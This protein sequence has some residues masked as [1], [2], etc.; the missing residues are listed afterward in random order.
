MPP[1]VEALEAR[2]LRHWTLREVHAKPPRSP[3]LALTSPLHT[4]ALRP[5]PQIAPT[6]HLP[7]RL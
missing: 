4:T 1:A 7:S 5:L 3:V 6:T 2:S